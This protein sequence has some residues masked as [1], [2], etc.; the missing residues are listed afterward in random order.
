MK[1][2]S[3]KTAVITGGASG[4]GYAI[5]EEALSRGMKVAIADVEQAALDQAVITLSEKGEVLAIKT[6]VSNAEQMDDFAKQTLAH[7]GSIHLVFNNAGVDGNGPMWELTTDDWNWTIGVNLWGV[8]HGIRVFSKHLVEQNEG[9]IINTA[10]IAG[11]VSAPGSGPYTATKHAVVAMSECLFGELRNE[12]KNVGVSVLCPSFVSTNI[13]K[14]GRNRKDF[15]DNEEKQAELKIIEELAG[16]LF[17][18]AMPACKVARMTFEAIES[19][20]F[21]ILPHPEG[22]KPLIKRRM[23]EILEGNL[24]SMKGPEE[25]PV[26]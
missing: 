17:A 12:G 19:K 8:V 23:D 21:Y 20:R 11:L 22:S 4:I 10:S 14:A 6:D 2:F 25:Y 9:H 26:A 16:G 1:E 5:A 7:Y 18:D 15:E 24:P 3:N 13:Y